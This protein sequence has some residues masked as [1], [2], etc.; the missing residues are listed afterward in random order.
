MA[1]S[2]R[3][4]FLIVC[5]IALA[6]GVVEIVIGTFRLTPAERRPEGPGRY[7]LAILTPL[8]LIVPPAAI[9]S[10]AGEIRAEWVGVRSLGVLLTLY[11]GGMEVWTFVTLRR[12][13]VPR[14]VVFPDHQLV[15]WGP[16]RFL[17]HPDYSAILA[18][19]LGYALGTLNMY[20]LILF[21]IVVVGFSMEAR[22]EEQLLES[23]FAQVYRDYARGKRRF[24]PHVRTP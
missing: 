19:W 8:L 7:L 17:R 5:A 20:L 21:P 16:Y 14:A 3:L 13:L 11:T 22:V 15:T 12:F 1:D 6:V 23:R 4:Y 10:R 18:L 24:V 2:F 9:L